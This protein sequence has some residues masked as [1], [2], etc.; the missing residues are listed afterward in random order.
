MPASIAGSLRVVALVLILAGVPGILSPV[1]QA[2]TGNYLIVTAQDYAGSAPLTQFAGAKT[3]MGFTV[4]MYVVPPGT[5]NTAIKAYIQG[6]WGTP[7]APR[8]LLIVGDTSGSTASANTIPHWVGGG[9]RAATTDLPYACMDG[10]SDWY[11]DIYI[12]R[13]SVTSVSMLQN[14]VSKTLYVEGGAYPDPDYIH[15]AAFLATD[16]A[17]AQAAQN[18]DWVIS[19]YLDPAGFESI[20]IY[21][22]YAHPSGTQDITDAVNQGCMFATYFGHST[23]SGWWSPSFN[24]ANVNALANTGLYGLVMGW[25]CNTSHFDYDEC[26]GETW[27]RAANKGAAAYLSASN[28]IWWST[29]EDWESSRRMERYF[30][31]SFFG[32]QIWEVGPAWRSALQRILEDPDFGP[33]HDHTRNIFEEFV[34][35]GDPA[36]LLPCGVG[37][38]LNISPATQNVCSPPTT[39]VQYT[40]Q[41]GKVGDFSEVVTLGAT[42]LPPGAS[43]AFSTNGLPPPF[44]SIMTISGLGPG[45]AGQ[46]TV[47]VSGSATSLNRSAGVGLNVSSGVPAAAV[48]TSP[49]DGATNVPLRPTFVW[50]AAAGS[51]RYN[52]QIAADAAFQNV[53]HSATTTATTYTPDSPLGTTTTYYWRVRGTNA[54]GEG[55]LSSEFSFTTLNML[56]PVAYDMPNGETG[57]YTY[58]D[59]TYNGQGDRNTPLAPLSGG[60]GDLTDGVIAT[61]H[62]NQTPLPYL[63]WKTVDPTIIVHFAGPVTLQTVTLYFD[64]SNGSGGVYPPTD[65]TIVVGG[66]TLTFP[67]TDPPSGDPFAVS[68]TGL[69]LTGSQLNLTIAD[70]NSSRYFMLSEMQ[71]YGDPVMAQGDLNCDG[72]VNMADIPHFVQALVDPAGYDGDHDGSPYAH[73]HRSLADMNSDGATDGLDVAG[74]VEA[75]IGG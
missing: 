61:A 11:P 52:L 50:Q 41:I 57:T 4:S 73:C 30:Y 15:R 16:D 5:T 45:G 28:Y 47:V 74:F 19:N 21:P 70:H 7:N 53:V 56:T 35:L 37:F 29:T 68:F 44:T 54:C 20:R 43:A 65:V 22:P 67:I 12:G 32:D 64:D 40:V 55:P 39:Q 9:S 1:A 60:V 59:D 48:L 71:F 26:F 38:T 14:V 33:L 10:P 62:W 31:Q 49:A 69:N 66:T 75:L 58:F 18:H 27:Q 51:L 72:T 42:G 13:F 63:S 2:G 17:T 46:H 25:S 34:L 8:Y 6:L 23:S 3:A 36:L 24:Q